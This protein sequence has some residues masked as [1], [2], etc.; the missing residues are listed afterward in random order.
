M[1]N[2]HT[3]FGTLK[4]MIVGQA[5]SPLE[6]ANEKDTET[7]ET[8]MRI[9]EETEEDL[10]VL[11]NILESAGVKVHRPTKQFSLER[12]YLQDG[13]SFA[14]DLQ[15]WGTCYP[16]H[17]LMPRDTVFVYGDTACEVWGKT[18]SRYFENWS[19]YPILEEKWKQGSRY[20][21]MPQPPI[22]DQNTDYD[23]QPILYE[24]A[25]VVK[26][27]SDVFYTQAFEDDPQRGKGNN[28]GIDWLKREF[29]NVDWNPIPVGGHADGKIAILKPGVVLTWDPKWVP[30]K[31]KD[32]GW[33]ILVTENGTK[34][35][36]EFKNTRKR[37]WYKEY[38][39]QWLNNWIGYVD[40]TVF[41]VNVVSISEKAVIC[42]G[43]DKEIFQ[44]FK[45]EGIE[46]I[47]WNFR[48]QYFWDGGV[49]CVTL[50]LARD[51]EPV[52]YFK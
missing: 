4:E 41:D 10:K 31:M 21:S 8:M 11:V 35:P 25:N 50:D 48:H 3:E 13:N 32:A 28:K 9:L 26:C 40:E 5:H 27:G 24:A 39:K 34:F 18:D 1:I 6:F 23:K 33:K 42:T 49:H 17:P 43:T 2:T 52:N 30:Q 16:N 15:H 46:P 29:S 47:Y 20:I 37:R 7:K 19:N 45:K 36:Q 51:D 12:K 14:Y 22:K 44:E 38:V